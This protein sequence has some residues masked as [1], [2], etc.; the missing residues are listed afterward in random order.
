M[1]DAER[2]IELA[3]KVKEDTVLSIE[4]CKELL[5]V[6]YSIDANLVVLQQALELAVANSQDAC[7]MVASNV[8]SLSGRTDNKAKKKAADYSA[9]VAAGLEISIQEYLVYASEQAEQMLRQL[10]EGNNPEQPT[11]SEENK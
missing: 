4:E 10:A 6:V 11:N 1:I 3:N 7:Q 2:F 8:L 5:E 9:R